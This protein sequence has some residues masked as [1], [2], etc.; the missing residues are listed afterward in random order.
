LS[1]WSNSYVSVDR[2]SREEPL[3]LQKPF[4]GLLGSIQPGVLPELGDNREDGLLDRILFT[5][6]EPVPSRWSD[7]EISHGAVDKYRDL[8][9][10]LRGLYMDKDDH[11]EPVPKALGLCE[12]A[13]GLLVANINRLRQE[14]E[15]P[16]FPERLKGPWSKLEA[17]FARLCLILALSR[18]AGQKVGEQVEADDVGNAKCLLDY[19]KNH[20]RRVSARLHERDSL[21]VLAEDL[22]AFLVLNGGRFKDEVSVLYDRLDSRHK[23]P[24]PEELSKR[25]RQLVLRY[26]HHIGFEDGRARNE[27]GKVQRYVEVFLKNAVHGV[28]AV[29]GGGS[30]G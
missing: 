23:G 21:E 8:Y 5:Y 9:N 13:K 25:L 1:A 26:S 12:D 19:F 4:A 30:V 11:E 10:A 7:E 6:P 29:H 2:K 27:E 20:A 18:T 24:R 17:Y 15:E 28:H 16:W 22:A 3:I 14:M